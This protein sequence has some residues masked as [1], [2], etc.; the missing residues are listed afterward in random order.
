MEPFQKIFMAHIFSLVILYIDDPTF[1]SYGTEYF[2]F[3][4]H[5]LLRSSLVFFRFLFHFFVSKMKLDF[6]IGLECAC[7]EFCWA[8]KQLV[9][10]KF[11]FQL[12]QK[13]ATI[14][15]HQISNRLSTSFKQEN[16]KRLTQDQTIQYTKLSSLP[17]CNKA[18]AFTEWSSERAPGIW[19]TKSSCHWGFGTPINWWE[20]RCNMMCQKKNCVIK[21]VLFVSGVAGRVPCFAGETAHAWVFLPDCIC[22][23]SGVPGSQTEQSKA[24]SRTLALWTNKSSV[25]KEIK[26]EKEQSLSKGKF[27]AQK[28][29]SK[30]ITETHLSP[31]Q[32]RRNPC[33]AGI[34]QDARE[35][36]KAALPFTISEMPCWKD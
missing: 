7:S 22:H 32:L 20:K 27:S 8:E 33:G 2:N 17:W 1:H 25:D 24:D 30:R 21:H 5:K 28:N 13:R 29:Y 35:G 23:I 9:P 18:A 31:P 19:S 3:Q 26:W 36:E 10:V 34:T 12:T 15:I 6:Y 4:V 14:Q 11:S 16:K